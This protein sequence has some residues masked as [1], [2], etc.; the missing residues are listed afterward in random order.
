MC[1]NDGGSRFLRNVIFYHSTRHHI[2]DDINFSWSICWCFSFT[3]SGYLVHVSLSARLSWP[4][5]FA[6]TRTRI[7]YN[8][9]FVLK[10]SHTEFLQILFKLLVWSYLYLRLAMRVYV[11]WSPRLRH[12]YSA[13]RTTVR[14]C[15]YKASILRYWLSAPIRT[16][17]IWLMFYPPHLST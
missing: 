9:V 4:Q 13:L 15:V 10:V 5:D 2:Q 6:H 3:S 8:L 12:L 17:Q 16:A 7:R 14:K 1:A 11:I